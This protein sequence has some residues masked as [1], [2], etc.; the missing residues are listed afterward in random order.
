MK[1]LVVEDEK[2]IADNIKK[3][4]ELKSHIVDVAY[5]GYDGYSFA[6]SEEYDVII[7][8]LMLPGKDGVTIC[9]QLRAEGDSTPIL[10][11]TAKTLVEDRVNG[12]DSGADDYLG[13]PFAFEELIARIHALSRRPQGVLVEELMV[14]DL[15]LDPKNYEVKRGSKKIDLSKKEFALLEFLMR[16]PG[17]VY[18]KEELTER[19]WEF[20][21]DVLPNTAQVYIGYLRNK[22]DKPFPNRKPLIQTVRGFGYKIGE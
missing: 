1:I 6:A 8:D 3:G 18:S 21:A 20:D 19:V 9:K 7:L 13:K 16:T 12:L 4:L 5:D 15:T 10:M 2:R 14:G 17:T 11:L 22:I